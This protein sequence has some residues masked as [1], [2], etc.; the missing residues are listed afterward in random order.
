MPAAG[1][2][3]GAIFLF[4]SHLELLFGSLNL[5]VKTTHILHVVEH[6]HGLKLA[7]ELLDLQ[8]LL[9]K[10]LFEVALPDLLLLA[11][12]LGRRLSRNGLRGA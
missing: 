3:L 5:A 1:L 8:L 2:L 7:L 12:A 9:E 11:L 6:F 10:L 4:N